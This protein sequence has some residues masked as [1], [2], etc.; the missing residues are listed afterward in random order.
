M[1][2]TIHEALPPGDYDLI[3]RGSGDATLVAAEI[4]AA[5]A[6]TADRP[7]RFPLTIEGN[8]PPP[9]WADISGQTQ[10]GYTLYV[11]DRSKPEA[12]SVSTALIAYSA[13]ASYDEWNAIR[14]GRLYMAKRVAGDRLTMPY[15]ELVPFL[16]REHIDA[17]HGAPADGAFLPGEK[18]QA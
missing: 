6:A 5:A 16:V 8:L 18:G 13:I 10:A 2:I 3:L 14:R 1:K 15:A 4:P 11:A 17:E 7:D 9:E 12:V